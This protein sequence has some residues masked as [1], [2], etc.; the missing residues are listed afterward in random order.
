MARCMNGAVICGTPR[1][2][3]GRRMAAHGKTPIHPRRRIQGP[4]TDCFAA[5]PGSASPPT[6]APPTGTAS[7]RAT[8]T[9]TSAFAPAA[10]SPQDP[11]WVLEPSG[12]LVLPWLLGVPPQGLANNIARAHTQ[13][14][15]KVINGSS[16]MR[17]NV[18]DVRKLV[19]R[20]KPVCAAGQQINCCYSIQV[21]GSK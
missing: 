2:W 16:H 11:L 3:A 20:S 9:L 4:P 19:Q 15:K 10:S 1:P 14:H 12:C 8:S 6:A 7:P 18:I 5:A 21:P 17:I 13:R